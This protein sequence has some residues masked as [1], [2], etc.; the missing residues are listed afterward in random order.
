MDVMA[1]KEAAELWGVI[2]RHVQ[3]LCDKGM[4]EGAIKLVMFDFC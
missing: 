3:A 1:T 2:V 4:I